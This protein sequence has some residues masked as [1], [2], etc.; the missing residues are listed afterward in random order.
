MVP[1]SHMS[2]GNVRNLDS[3]SADDTVVRKR[4]ASVNTYGVSPTGPSDCT[5]C[6]GN[7][8]E[9]VPGV[10]TFRSAWTRSRLAA[11]RR[12]NVVPRVPLS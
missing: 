3:A 9:R 10:D 2:P 7:V 4:V 12:P 1:G 5:P 6:T 8:R 11:R